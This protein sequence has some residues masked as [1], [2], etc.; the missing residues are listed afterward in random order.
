MTNAQLLLG[1]QLYFVQ[2]CVVNL[3]LANYDNYIDIILI[4]YVPLRL[5]FPGLD[6]SMQ[7]VAVSFGQQVRVDS[8]WSGSCSS[9]CADIEVDAGIAYTEIVPPAGVQAVPADTAEENEFSMKISQYRATKNGK[10]TKSPEGF[11]LRNCGKMF[12]S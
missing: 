3:L 1:P 8:M 10:K 9:T 5:D 7:S 6:T 12:H 11:P 4:L 2:V